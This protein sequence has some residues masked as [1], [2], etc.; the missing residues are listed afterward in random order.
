MAI[1]R[2]TA[3]RE[4]DATLAE[5]DRA[6]AKSKHDDGSDLPELELVATRLV[7]TIERFAPTGSFQARQAAK[8]SAEHWNAH[9]MMFMHLPGVL[10]GLRDDIANGRLASVIELV[11][12]D[13]FTDFL[14]MA[15][16]LLDDG[17]YK[18]AAAVIAGSSLE[19]HLRALSDKHGIATKDG[20]GTPKKAQLLNQELDKSGAYQGKTEQKNV[21]AWLGLRNDAAH[22]DYAKYQPAQVGLL[23][24]S[25]RDFITRYPA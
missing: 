6:A 5:F 18:D 9:H 12:A 21:T 10:R 8:F 3:L 4:I 7:T 22:G 1:D 19:A 24:A 20:Q 25:I 14:D 2:D 13:V 16:H 17:G 23:I 15:Q 11:H